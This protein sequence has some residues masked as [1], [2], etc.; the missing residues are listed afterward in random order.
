MGWAKLSLH[1]SIQE[2]KK[3]LATVTFPASTSSVHK[4]V[5]KQPGQWLSLRTCSAGQ[6]GQAGAVWL[7]LEGTSCLT[8]TLPVKPLTGVPSTHCELWSDDWTRV[9]KL[10]TSLGCYSGLTTVQDQCQQEGSV[11]AAGKHLFL[12]R[13]LDKVTRAWAFGVHIT[14]AW[15]PI[16]ALP[17]MV[18]VT[19][20]RWFTLAKFQFPYSTKC[21]PCKIVF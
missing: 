16:L 1:L 15:V 3:T 18:L 21:P 6:C 20:G 5:V 13:L 2:L 12:K 8:N 10:F 9:P 11:L 4:Q 19:L 14:Q 17:L 7:S